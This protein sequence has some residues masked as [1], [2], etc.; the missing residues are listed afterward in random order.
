MRYGGK[1][2]LKSTRINGLKDGRIE[3]IDVL[4]SSNPMNPNSDKKA[5][6]PAK[7]L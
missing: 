7:P 4:K 5:W 1:E 2:I 6:Y 3:K